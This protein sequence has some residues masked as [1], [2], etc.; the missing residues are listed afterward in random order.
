MFGFLAAPLS[1]KLGTHHIE[2]HCIKIGF[3]ILYFNVR[4]SSWSCWCRFQPP[5]SPC[6][7]A[8]RRRTNSLSRLDLSGRSSQSA[9]LGSSPG[10][11]GCLG[12]DPGSGS[13]AASKFLGS[14][15]L[16]QSAN[17]SANPFVE[18]SRMRLDEKNQMSQRH[19]KD[20]NTRNGS[21]IWDVCIFAC[22]KSHCD[23]I[24]LLLLQHFIFFMFGR[25]CF[26][27]GFASKFFQPGMYLR[28]KSAVDRSKGWL[29][30]FRCLGSFQNLPGRA[31][32]KT[33]EKLLNSPNIEGSSFCQTY[34][35]IL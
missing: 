27:R 21:Y 13:V 22:G 2:Q 4:P 30:G 16:N 14:I 19:S 18:K 1:L 25:T 10:C 24:N 15:T 32:D 31:G 23:I 28:Q 20:Q 34:N 5:W 33:F 3:F 8:L 35:Y 7:V 26:S 29:D 11:S 6:F 12:E 17:K 9:F